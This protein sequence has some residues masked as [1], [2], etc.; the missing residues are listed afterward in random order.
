M[1]EE[2]ISEL[3]HEPCNVQ[4]VFEKYFS[5]AFFQLCEEDDEFLTVPSADADHSYEGNEPYREMASGSSRE[6]G[7]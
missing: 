5:D 6:E 7:N 4:V 1:V 2:T 3:S